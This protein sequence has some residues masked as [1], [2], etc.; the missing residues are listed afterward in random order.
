MVKKNTLRTEISVIIC[1]IFLSCS[2]TAYKSDAQ[3]SASKISVYFNT[4]VNNSVS[5][6]VNAVYLNHAMADT[7]VAYM[8][9]AKYTIDIAQYDYNQSASYAN[10]A[11]AINNCYARGV[12]IRWIYDGSQSNTGLASLNSGIPTLASPTTSAYGI[13]HDKFVVID[14][15]SSNPNDAIVSTGSEDWGVTQFN[16]ANN[17]ILFIQDSALAHAYRNEFNMM[18]GDT[19]M[20]PNATTSKFG[21]YKTDLGA[22]IFHIGGKT[23][24]LYFSPSDHTDSHIQSSINS[25]NTDLY[26]GVYT[27]TESTDAN[28]IVA[29]H[30][31]GVYTL[32]IVDQYSN[33]G[34][35]YP[36]LTS[37]LGSLMKTFASS[38]TIYH[39]K[40]LIVDPSNTC[41]DPLVLTGSHNWTVSADTKNDEN[42]L[43]I[44]SDTIANIYY[45][46]FYGNYTALGGTLNAIAPCTTGCSTP[47][48]LN[49]TSITTSSANLSWT[50]V[51]GATSY[52]IQYRIIGSSTW[53]TTTSGTNSTSLPGL[54]AATNYEFEVQT[55][56][57][58]GS[59]SFS[60]SY[61][62]TTLANPCSVPSGLF[63]SG[64]TSTSATLNWLAISGAVSYNIQYRQTG[65]ITW[66]NTTST[67]NSVTIAGLTP[68]TIYEFQVQVICSPGSSAFSAPTQFTTPSIT[69]AIPPGASVTSITTTTAIL[70]WTTVTGAISYT[71]EYRIPG[72][73]AWSYSSSLT[74]SLSLSGLT[75][76][77]TYE[78]QIQSICSATDSSG[79]SNSTLFTTLAPC[80]LPSNLLA[81]NITATSALL[82]WT[83]ISGAISYSIQYRVSGTTSW[84]NT[85]SSINSVSVTGLISGTTYEFQVQAICAGGSGAYSPPSDFTTNL[86]ICPVPT[87][88][89]ATS[90][91]DT[92]TIL[93]WAAVSGAIRY[94]INYRPSG[95]TSWNYRTSLSTSLPIT[96]I[97]PGVTYEFMVQAICTASDSSGYSFTYTAFPASVAEISPESDAIKN[98]VIYPDPA[99]ND[100]TLSYDLYQP[101][102]ISIQLFHM[103]GQVVLQIVH[104]E[105]QKT[106][107]HEYKINLPSPGFYFVKLTTGQSAITKKLVKL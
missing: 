100:A 59:S 67:V 97:L 11:T 47:S 61:N 20:T 57:A 81:T 18:W 29:L 92:I 68:G 22:H 77:T 32:G 12:R 87:G 25:A 65:T 36:I 3:T 41:S 104:S 37:G 21:P 10:I 23:I 101:E 102:N 48:G 52:T 53:T 94:S 70:H 34:A 84:I 86:P 54:A 71:I 5:T 55:I 72:T 66:S 88:L 96:G 98:F 64:I 75:A 83:S 93:S 27:F 73:T 50:A 16:S 30:N 63:A 28:D 74:N 46:A 40:M 13:M 103:T 4:P 44:H 24:E 90:F 6:G 19:S 1:I 58:S 7:L 89:S 31:T 76:G 15:N 107:A 62:F 42:T 105:L 39:N 26:F 60:S 8:S 79:Y 69:C 35:A 43:I 17:N 106:G 82:N 91:N 78:S 2:I 49:A 45:Q 51:T 33:T 99:I 9:R 38:S 85:T 95:T 80:G 14:A 56:C